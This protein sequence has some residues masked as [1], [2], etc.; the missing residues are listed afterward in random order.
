MFIVIH[1]SFSELCELGILT[2]RFNRPDKFNA[3][4]ADVYNKFISLLNMGSISSKVKV[5]YLTGTGKYFTAGNDL[6]N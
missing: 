5:I 1:K 4:N 3:L 6:S 2:I